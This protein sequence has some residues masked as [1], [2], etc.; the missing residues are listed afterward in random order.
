[1]R[2]VSLL[3]SPLTRPSVFFSDRTSRKDIRKWFIIKEG[4]GRTKQVPCTSIM[5]TTP[6]IRFGS[7][8]SGGVEGDSTGRSGSDWVYLVIPFRFSMA[9]WIS[10]VSFGSA[11]RKS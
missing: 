1:M 7:L 2:Q 8:S 11:P 10:T 6:P 9:L 3:L 5:D 4:E